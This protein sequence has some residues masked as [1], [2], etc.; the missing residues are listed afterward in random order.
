MFACLLENFLAYEFP[1]IREP[2]TPLQMA[3]LACPPRIFDPKSRPFLCL[4][5]LQ[6]TKNISLKKS[7]CIVTYLFFGNIPEIHD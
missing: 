3:K 1:C 4:V 2:M 6:E 7:T 5:D